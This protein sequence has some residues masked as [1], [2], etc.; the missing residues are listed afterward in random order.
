MCKWEYK[1][2]VV[3]AMSEDRWNEIGREGWE[4]YL[5]AGNRHMF[6]RPLAE[7]KKEQPAKHAAKNR[8]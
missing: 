3:E 5:T 6:K 8:K 7:D 1:K 2:E 4:H